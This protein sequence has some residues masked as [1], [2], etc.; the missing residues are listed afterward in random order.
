MRK[1]FYLL[2]LLLIF[3]SVF[4]ASA[5]EDGKLQ[6]TLRRNFGYAGGGDIQGAFTIRAT[7][8]AD[9]QRV[10]FFIDEVQ[11]GEA[12]QAPFELRFHTDSYSLGQHTLTAVGSTASGLEIPSDIITIGFVSASEGWQA[13]MRIALPLLG[14]VLA[15]LVLSF[16]VSVI[17][18]GKLKNLPPGTPRNYGAAGGAICPRCGR[19]F[20]RHVISMNMLVGKL[21]RCPYCGKWSI[22]AAQPPELLRAAEA[23]EMEGQNAELITTEGE[24]ERLKKELDE[25]RFLEP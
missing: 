12:T 9:L 6:L 19:P 21:E 3:S 1:L 23:A 24:A 11:I 15:L 14:I 2:T 16:V 20:A 8:P 7:G 18:G 4:P 17:T 25:S 22:L 5:Q 13:G 10:V